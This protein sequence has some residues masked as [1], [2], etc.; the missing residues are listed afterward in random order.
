MFTYTVECILYAGSILYD[1]MHGPKNTMF[2]YLF[3]IEPCLEFGLLILLDNGY[4]QCCFY[5]VNLGPPG[6]LKS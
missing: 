1:Y 3:D 5:Q 2:V 6:G 4:I